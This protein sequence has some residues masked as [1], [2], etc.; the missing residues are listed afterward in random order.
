MMR[1]RLAVAVLTVTLLGLMAVTA[2]QQQAGSAP[3]QPVQVLST[4]PTPPS[5]ATRVAA[6]APV[7][8]SQ[9]TVGLSATGV[10]K[11]ATTITI[12]APSSM[13]DGS[14]ALVAISVTASKG[15]V[16]DFRTAGT[17]PVGTVTLSV[18]GGTPFSLGSLN[19]GIVTY[20]FRPGGGPGPYTLVA[21]YIPTGN[22]L[23]SSASTTVIVTSGVS[24][25]PTTTTISAPS[26][27]T[28]GSSALVT[29]SVTSSGAFGARSVPA[30]VAP[31]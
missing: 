30:L 29:I 24:K 6:P 2:A 19:G 31:A 3:L 17:A 5:T 27:M 28:Y 21:T 8:S 16:T 23:G 20:Q 26:S 14:S 11:I 15:V 12:S 1:V 18:S 13:T 4:K 9:R 7:S 25:V 22:F 10:D